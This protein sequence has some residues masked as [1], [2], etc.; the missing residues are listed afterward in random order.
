MSPGMTIPQLD[1]RDVKARLDAG[2][3]DLVL[4]DVREPDELTLARI[5]GVVHVPMNEIPGALDRLDRA[6]DYVVV[7]H[8][9]IR[10]SMVCNFLRAKGYPRVSNLRGGIEAWYRE[11]DP[12]VGHY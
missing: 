4:L 11:V 9:G 2:A 10:S 6:R 1:P 5:D 8:H 7:C 3:D 12:S